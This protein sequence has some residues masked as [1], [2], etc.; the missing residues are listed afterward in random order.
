M[1]HQTTCS[2]CGHIYD[3]HINVYGK[4]CIYCGTFIEPE[5]EIKMVQENVEIKEKYKEIAI[6]KV[7]DKLME[8]E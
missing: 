6:S 7:R 5:I 8:E 3:G 4:I 2:S 1:S